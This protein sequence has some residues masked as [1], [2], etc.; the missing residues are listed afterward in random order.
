MKW[1]F[2]Y[3]AGTTNYGLMFD[4]DTAK[5]EVTG[6]VDSDYAGDL[7]ARIS[8]TGFVYTFCG[9]CICWRSVLQSTEALSTTEAEY[10]TLTEASK[11]ALWLKG[12]IKELGLKQ[13]NIQIQCDSQSAIHLA[14]NQVF[15]ARTKHIDVRYHKIREWLNN[16]DIAIRK[17]HTKENAA[18]M[19]TK[20]VTTE[21]FKHC[22]DLIHFV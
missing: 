15:H 12:L 8:T 22:L 11:E 4:R 7:D 17:V 13:G 2:H 10:M 14:K 1:T 3:L 19:L 9:G 18:Y 6:F 21:K 20:S 5:S 16:G